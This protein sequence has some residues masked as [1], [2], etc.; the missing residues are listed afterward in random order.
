TVQV[1]IDLDQDGVLD[2]N[3]ATQAFMLAPASLGAVSFAA[4][5]TSGTAAEGQYFEINANDHFDVGSTFAFQISPTGTA[6]FGDHSLLKYQLVDQEGGTIL[7]D[8]SG[9]KFSYP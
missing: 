3:E 1:G 8:G 4:K 9:L 6:A 2:P 7:R 5:R